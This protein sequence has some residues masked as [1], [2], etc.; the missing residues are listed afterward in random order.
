VPNNLPNKIQGVFPEP[1]FHK[2]II[3]DHTLPGKRLVLRLRTPL[4]KFEKM[5]DKTLKKAYN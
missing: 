2:D 5:F 4:K 3:G 1:G